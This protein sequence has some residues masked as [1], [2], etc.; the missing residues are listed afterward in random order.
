MRKQVRG[1]WMAALAAAI[2][3]LPSFGQSVT[4]QVVRGQVTETSSVASRPLNN[5]RFSPLHKKPLAD[6]VRR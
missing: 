3:S 2:C 6:L 5:P 4:V 1:L